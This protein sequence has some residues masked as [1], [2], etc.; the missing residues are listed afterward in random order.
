[1]DQIGPQT[2]R[3][4]I[5]PLVLVEL[6]M[7]MV[8]IAGFVRGSDGEKS[9]EPACA[10]AHMCPTRRLLPYVSLHGLCFFIVDGR[11]AVRPCVTHNMEHTNPWPHYLLKKKIPWPH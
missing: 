8:F 7:K 3:D 10:Y 2:I 11:W 5:S 6:V 4:N 1:M 9:L